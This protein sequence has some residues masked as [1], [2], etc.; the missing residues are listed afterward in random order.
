MSNFQV[1]A[2]FN[3]QAAIRYG[4]PTPLAQTASRGITSANVASALAMARGG[5]SGVSSNFQ[6]QSANQFNV[7]YQSQGLPGYEGLSNYAASYYG[8][9][10]ASG[11]SV[12]GWSGRTDSLSQSFSSSVAGAVSGGQINAG[13]AGYLAG[14]AGDIRGMAGVFAGA[15]VD[16]SLRFGYQGSPLQ[17]ASYLNQLSYGASYRAEGNYSSAYSYNQSY[18]GM[19]SAFG[20]YNHWGAVSVGHN[21]AGGADPRFS[22][23]QGQLASYGN[24]LNQYASQFGALQGN[25]SALGGRV[26]H[27]GQD[28]NFLK[29][30]FAGFGSQISDLSSRVTTNQAQAQA[31]LSSLDSK[32]SNYQ[33]LNDARADRN[34]KTIAELQ[35]QL[36]ELRA[37]LGTDVARV[38]ARIDKVETRLTTEVS[39]LSDRISAV[40]AKLGAEIRALD[41][42]FTG[43]IDKLK[44]ADSALAA[45]F[46]GL[47]KQV[48][49]QGEQLAK[50]LE[51]IKGQGE[52]MAAMKTDLQNQLNS[53]SADQADTKAK[54]Q[55]QIAELDAAQADIGKLQSGL[56]SAKA[57]YRSGLDT[58]GK[59][60]SEA[61][62]RIDAVNGK[63]D[64]V[65]NELNAKIDSTQ[66]QLQGQISN[67][68]S[69]V[70]KNTADIANV[71]RKLEN[72]VNQMN[73]YLAAHPDKATD[74]QITAQVSR[75]GFV[76]YRPWRRVFGVWQQVTTV[77]RKDRDITTT[78]KIDPNQEHLQSNTQIRENVTSQTSYNELILYKGRYLGW[79]APHYH[80]VTIGPHIVLR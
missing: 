78:F 15:P 3:A 48:N 19:M 46:E 42:K 80:A 34:E 40:D 28:V 24:T 55:Q 18:S 11:Y 63:V 64:T 77:V 12:G 10:S 44:A 70:S 57:E 38:D 23:L 36:A 58:L 75:Y 20:Q 14:L 72:T 73:E 8:S 32:L 76:A 59:Q 79:A 66:Q 56:E 53:L 5:F 9:Q 35:A 45:K 62:Q 74:T 26:D 50:Q 68:Q 41:S 17:S 6:L 54:L 37:K 7:Q 4:A 29:G 39:A 22:A 52:S 1:N 30:Q 43:E 51:M 69:Q 2:N 33:T 13:Q 21:I 27:L 25:L 16:A 31:G 49:A 65:R 60:L 67:L 47:Q 71:D 61:N